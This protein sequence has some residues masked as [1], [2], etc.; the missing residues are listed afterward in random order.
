MPLVLLS[1]D[2]RELPGHKP[3]AKVRPHRPEVFL[4]E[5]YAEAVRRAGG[6]PL[7]VPPG[8]TDVDALLAVA[9]AVVLTGGHFDIHP[10]HYGQAVRAR[11]DRVEEGRTSLELSLARACVARDVPVL[12]ICGGMQAMAVAL[13]GTLIQ[14]LV[15]PPTTLEHEQPTDPATAWHT[16]RCEGQMAAW[17]GASVEANS[18]HHQAVAH[19]GPFT[20]SGWSEDGTVEAMHLDGHRFAAGVQWHP[21]LLGD[22]RLYAALITAC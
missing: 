16:V 11:L 17:L 14:H 1:A 19:T 13:G 10:S 2:R 7:L 15:G 21:E 20:A 9:D 6:T 5:A 22:D 8:E 12:G 3:G 4:T 18:T